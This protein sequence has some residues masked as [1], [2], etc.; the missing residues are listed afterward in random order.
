MLNRTG[1][2]VGHLHLWFEDVHDVGLHIE[3]RRRDRE[4]LY[5]GRFGFCQLLNTVPTGAHFQSHGV[6]ARNFINVAW[7]GGRRRGSISKIPG[8][9]GGRLRH[10]KILEAHRQRRTSGDRTA[11]KADGRIEQHLHFRFEIPFAALGCDRHFDCVHPRLGEREA[12]Q[13]GARLDVRTSRRIVPLERR[14]RIRHPDGLEAEAVLLEALGARRLEVRLQQPGY[15]EDFGG[16]VRALE[17]RQRDQLHHIRSWAIVGPRREGVVADVEVPGLPEFPD[18]TGAPD[19]VVLEIQ[20]ETGTEIFLG[21]DDRRRG[22]RRGPIQD[23]AA[24]ATVLDNGQLRFDILDVG[25]P[26]ATR[27]GEVAGTARS[28]GSEIP[29]KIRTVVGLDRP[30]IKHGCPG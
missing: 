6:R 21:G 17:V 30:K 1:T 20:G 14:F 10:R 11:I 4:D 3:S 16:G 19:T 25:E 26:D 24:D 9:A 23:A 15:L 8:V 7:I 5:K 22:R 2:E 12:L 18:I 28:Q 13:N 29:A 27:R